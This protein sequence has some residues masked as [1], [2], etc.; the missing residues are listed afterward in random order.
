MERF[1][2]DFLQFSNTTIK[3]VFFG[4]PAGKRPFKNDVTAK[5]P[6]F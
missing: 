5:I 4:W 3:N 6:N 2:T 1:T